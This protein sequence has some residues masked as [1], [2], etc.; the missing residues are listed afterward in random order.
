MNQ[1][2]GYIEPTVQQMTDS[3]QQSFQTL[4]DRVVAFQLSNAQLAQNFFQNFVEQLQNQAQGAEQ[5]TED[6]WQQGDQQRQAFETLAQASIDAY[7]DFLNSSLS[8]YQETLSSY[9][10]AFR[11]GMQAVEQPKQESASTPERSRE[12]IEL[13][14]EW[15]ADESGYDEET[16]P[17]LKAALERDRLSDHSLFVD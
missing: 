7:N 10:Q 8:F 16:W 15:L 1:H 2:Q 6:L 13:L 3:M 9:Q 17:E 4:T 11:Q 12:A 5:V 14:D